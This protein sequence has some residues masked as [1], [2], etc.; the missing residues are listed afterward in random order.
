MTI[1][2]RIKITPTMLKR[3]AS[4]VWK[5]NLRAGNGTLS[6]TSGVLH[7]APFSFK[8]SLVNEDGKAGTNPEE[9]LAA[10][11]AG[12]YAM[13]VGATLDQA[14]FTADVLEVNAILT[15]DT[16][17]LTITT[18]ELTLKGTVPGVSQAQ[19]MEIAE[20]ASKGCIISKALASDIVITLNAT[21]AE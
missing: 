21:L 1:P 16:D 7:N 12:C 3:S 9:L 17:V 15:L 19:F 13:A 11:H 10:A 5:G 18:I 8:T 6:A 2:S 4:A 20:G 14:G